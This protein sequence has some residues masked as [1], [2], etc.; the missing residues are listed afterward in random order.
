M[1][2]STRSV[3]CRRPWIARPRH[4]P[5]GVKKLQSLLIVALAGQPGHQIEAQKLLQEFGSGSTDRL[6]ELINGLSAL[7]E[8]ASADIR[9]QLAQLQLTALDQ[10]ASSDS[11]LDARQRLRIEQVRAG[12]LRAS[13]RQDAALQL[14]QQLAVDQPD[15]GSIQL[16]L[17]EM[18]LESAD[19]ETLSAAV[20]QWQKLARRVRPGTDDWFRARYC[21]AFALFK[22]NRPATAKEPSD[23]AVAAQ[24]LQYLKATSNVDETDWKAKVD[25]LLQRC[26]GG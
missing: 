2:W 21:V 4:R 13:G 3:S 24:R 8:T 17:A 20:A 25:E 22:R 1:V 19:K 26:T 5:L 10:L 12:A 23:R 9:A 18:M 7:A 6:L 14:F 11:Q 16:E 15:N